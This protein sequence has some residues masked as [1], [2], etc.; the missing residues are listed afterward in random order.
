MVM[1]VSSDTREAEAMVQA[2]VSD[3]ELRERQ[4]VSW[5]VAG[6]CRWIDEDDDDGGWGTGMKQAGESS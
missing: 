2:R 4:S 6:V 5:R 3:D 1:G